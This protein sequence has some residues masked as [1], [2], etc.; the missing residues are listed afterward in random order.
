MWNFFK[1]TDSDSVTWQSKSSTALTSFSRREKVWNSTE[2]KYNI[3]QNYGK[4]FLNLWGNRLSES[5]ALAS[6]QALRH[7][8][9]EGA[10]HNAFCINGALW[11]CTLQWG[12]IREV[13]IAYWLCDF[14]EVI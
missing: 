14:G 1:K 13:S 6:K 7:T 5:M 8:S 3:L 9:P 4:L 12:W 10:V 11:S 2:R